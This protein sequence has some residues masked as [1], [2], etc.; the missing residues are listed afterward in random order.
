M[1]R[2][3]LRQLTL[4]NYRRL[5][6]SQ[7]GPV[8]VF[9]HIY[10]NH[11][12]GDAETASGSDSTVAATVSLRDKIRIW[13]GEYGIRSVAD[14]PCGD[15]NWFR[16]VATDSYVGG[17]IVPAVIEQNRARFP[18]RKFMVL[19]ARSHPLPPAD[20][21][22]CR[23]LLDHLSNRDIALFL[24]NLSRSEFKYAAFSHFPM[25]AQL[26]DIVTGCHRLIDLTK[27]PVSF[28]RPLE[29]FVESEEGEQMLTLS[30]WRFDDLREHLPSG[31]LAG[32]TGFQ[33]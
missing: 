24:K 8:R 14:I 27:P 23:H 1:L 12:W 4:G 15:H 10:K 9:D 22:L 16:L 2:R 3:K 25:P 7:L 30:L 13:I 21:L 20:L 18:A 32:E 26:P 5:R 31:E 29:V 6:Y 28:P 19:D 11:H 33:G 17:D